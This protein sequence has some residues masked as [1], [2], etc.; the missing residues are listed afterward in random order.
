MSR[1]ANVNFSAK[2]ARVPLLSDQGKS[3]SQTQEAVLSFELTGNFGA[4]ANFIAM[5][6]NIPY[7]GLI[8]SLNIVPQAEPGQKSTGK[9]LAKINYI[10]FN[11]DL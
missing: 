5:L 2:S 3:A 11:F 10:I 7:A 4:V 8:E 1:E 9:L 6:D